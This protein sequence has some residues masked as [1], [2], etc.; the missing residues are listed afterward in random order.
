MHDDWKL[1]AVAAESSSSSINEQLLSPSGPPAITARDLTCTFDGGTTYQLQAANYNLPRGRRVGLVG[2]NGCGKS[3]FLRI[4]AEACGGNGGASGG[5]ASSSS[6]SG[7]NHLNN[8]HILFTGTVECPKGVS[9]AFVEQEPPSPSD[10]TVLDA[11][12]GIITTKTTTTEL[13]T[14]LHESFDTIH[15]SL[16]AANPMDYC[17]AGGVFREELFGYVCNFLVAAHEHPDGGL[18]IHV[19]VLKKY[20]TEGRELALALGAQQVH[21]YEDS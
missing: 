20:A 15:V 6:S 7:I 8:D 3:T 19:G 12:L 14:Q 13:I 21:V 18:P 4:L 11:L 9:L 2:R 17:Q 1:S 16:L 5:G 10:V